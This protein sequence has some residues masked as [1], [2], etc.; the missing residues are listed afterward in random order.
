[1]F[2]DW[3]LPRPIS[4]VIWRKTNLFSLCVVGKGT[5]IMSEKK[6]GDFIEILGPFK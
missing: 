4:I 1:M 5:K 6:V 3:T 2:E